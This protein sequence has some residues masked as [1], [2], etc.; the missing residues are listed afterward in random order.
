MANLIEK[1]GYDWFRNKFSSSY[2]MYK[3]IPAQILEVNEDEVLAQLA[4]RIN[5]EVKRIVT[6]VEADYFPDSTLFAVPELGY[7]H[8]QDGRYLTYVSRNNGSYHRG[9]SPGNTR[10]ND[11]EHTIILR[12]NGIPVPP[13]SNHEK[14]NLIMEPTFI[15]FSRGIKLM[16]EGKIMSFA[17]SPT[18]AVVPNYEDDGLL[19]RM[20]SKDIGTVSPEGEVTFTATLAQNYLE[21]T[22]WRQ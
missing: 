11:S 18:I 10:L 21:G 19:I 5:G 3:G 1:Y 22:L 12:D 6:E 9:L 15:P 4:P 7:R 13:L 16:L 20:C 14:C 17:A 2:F 8:A